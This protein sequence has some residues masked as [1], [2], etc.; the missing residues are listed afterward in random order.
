MHG[1]FDTHFSQHSFV[2]ISLKSEGH[3][4]SWWRI[5]RK[6]VPLRLY[7]LTIARKKSDPTTENTDLTPGIVQ[8]PHISQIK[9]LQ[10]YKNYPECKEREGKGNH[11]SCDFI[12]KTE[13]AKGQR[14]DWYF[15]CQERKLMQRTSFC[16]LPVSSSTSCLSFAAKIK[17]HTTKTK[18]SGGRVNV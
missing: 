9:A 16:L 17:W 18:G 12:Q 15:S 6:L 11:T 4:Q 2:K 10:Q 8:I 13:W 3:P 7:F 5:E 14:P 1:S